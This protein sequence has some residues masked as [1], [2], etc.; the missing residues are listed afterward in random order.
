MTKNNQIDLI[1]FPANSPE[2]LQKVT[3]FF[4]EVFGW[5]YK[6]WGGVYSDTQDSGVASGVNASD[7][8]ERQ[9]KPLAVIY[10]EDLEVAKQK[11]IDAGGTVTQ[12]IYEFPGGRRFHF[13]DPA[14]N[15]LAV[16]G[17]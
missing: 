13:T 15:E 14:G 4:T 7:V 9:V 16:W 5:Q 1:E 2:E 17:E 12:D 6:D 8:G 3:N 10:S 11:V